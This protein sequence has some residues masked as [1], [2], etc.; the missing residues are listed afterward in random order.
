MYSSRSLGVTSTDQPRIS[1]YHFVTATDGSGLP[2]LLISL[3][4]LSAGSQKIAVD[5]A[6]KCESTR[7]DFQ[8]Q[9]DRCAT[10]AR[11]QR[12]SV[13]VFFALQLDPIFGLNIV[14]CALSTR[15]DGSLL[16]AAA[17]M[18]LSATVIASGRTIWP[19]CLSIRSAC[20]S[21][22]KVSIDHGTVVTPH[23]DEGAA[24]HAGRS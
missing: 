18:D 21:M 12:L 7:H 19:F 17:W 16:S 9:V 10:E 4:S 1:R 13:Q 8:V 22:F 2:C 14:R 5:R 3:R 11:S 23:R 24:L 6:E 20:A 15:T